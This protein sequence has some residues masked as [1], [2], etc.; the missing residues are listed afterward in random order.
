LAERNAIKALFRSF[1]QM[2]RMKRAVGANDASLEFD[3]PVIFSHYQLQYPKAD[4]LKSNCILLA[5]PGKPPRPDNLREM[6][7]LIDD[8]EWLE[9]WFV[10]LFAPGCTDGTRKRLESHYKNKLVIIDE[11][12]LLNM[13]LAESRDKTPLGRLRSLMLHA[14][15]EESVEVFRF[16]QL[17]N[18]RTA[19]FVGRESRIDKIV[20]SDGSFAL[21]GGRRIGKSSILMEIQDQLKQRGTTVVDHS[22]EGEKDCSDDAGARKLARQLKLEVDGIDDFKTAIQDYMDQSPNANLVILL[23]EIDRY[24]EEN[25]QR[26]ILIEAL[27]SLADKYAGRFRV[28]VA[29]FMRLYECLNGRGP[30]TPT[31][32]PWQRMFNKDKPVEN[33][34]AN[35]AEKIVREGFLDILGWE[36]ENRGIP[37]IIVEK[38]GCHPAF[39]QRFCDLL[40]SRVTLRGNRIIRV[41]D[42]DAV[43]RDPD[44]SHSFIAYVRSTLEMNL[45]PIS[46]Y[47]ILWLAAES[48]ANSFTL[49]LAKY[50]V[51][52]CKTTIPENQLMQ[53]LDHL[54][55]TSVVEEK[56][57]G[58]Y[59]FSVPDYP[60]ILQQLG[61]TKH[62][63]QLEMEISEYLKKNGYS[64]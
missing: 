62:I 15:G 29:G 57:T 47:L 42:V 26:H 18:P 64:V 11:Q 23:D 1:T 25:R 13:V 5:M 21:Y 36:F 56:S 46:R 9:D 58:V 6:E 19:I 63:E 55:V 4:V 28:V 53:S 30:Y 8:R 41:D 3:D 14:Y 51:Q 54:K 12:T 38:T 22:F 61:D 37:Q 48:Q 27:R 16:N 43:F 52:M 32:D 24:I 31:S 17:V 10:L 33:V 50:I 44:P 7:H 2:V 34:R 39:V 45:N 60:V 49:D 35:S 59:E 20:N 40:Q